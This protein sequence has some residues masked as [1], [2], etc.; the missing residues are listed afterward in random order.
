MRVHQKNGRARVTK[1]FAVSSRK[2]LEQM[3]A[4]HGRKVVT[5]RSNHGEWNDATS[6]YA[7]FGDD[8]NPDNWFMLDK[9]MKGERRNW[10]D[11]WNA[12]CDEFG[13]E[14]D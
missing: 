14:R 3:L 8:S 6:F 1:F 10:Q 4:E 13:L 9:C 5:V 7:V 11:M 12:F 2:D